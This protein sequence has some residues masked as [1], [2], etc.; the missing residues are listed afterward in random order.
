MWIIGHSY[1]HWAGVRAEVRPA[2]RQLSFDREVAQV[3]WLGRRGMVWSRLL[4][5]FQYYAGLGSVVRSSS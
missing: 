3:R 2:G 4:P 1:V 5:E